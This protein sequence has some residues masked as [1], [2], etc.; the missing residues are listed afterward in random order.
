[1]GARSITQVWRSN[2]T[3]QYLRE[4]LSLTTKK[5]YAKG[6]D[7]EGDAREFLVEHNIK[8]DEFELVTVE[9]EDGKGI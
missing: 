7:A 8:E 3:G 2:E 9:I 4:D 6:F 1:M 5:E